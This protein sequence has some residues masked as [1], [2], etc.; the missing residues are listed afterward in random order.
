MPALFVD[1]AVSILIFGSI[2]TTL[3]WSDY[4]LHPETMKYWLNV[5]GEIHFRLPGVFESNPDN[6]VNGSLW[7][8]KPELGCYLIMTLLIA[9]GL[10]KRWPVTLAILVGLW[11]ASWASQQVPF[12]FT[13][14]H[15]L[16]TDVSKLVIFFLAGSLAYLLRYKIPYSP[17][18]A[19][20]SIAFIAA[21]AILAEGQWLMDSRPFMIISIPALTYLTIWLGLQKIPPLPLFKTGDY[22]YG[23][24]LYAYPIQQIVVQATGTREPAI[25]FLLTIVP[26]T[27]VAI[28]SW[29][30]VEKPTLKLRKYLKATPNKPIAGGKEQGTAKPRTAIETSRGGE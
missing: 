29:H 10:V 28:A 12:D 13:G 22:S 6:S 11:L 19:G 30:L 24:Y 5:V 17:W 14:K 18:I 26:V 4:I 25:T 20:A 21:C 3:D 2:L 1:T 8:I 9:S 15:Q 23:I 16:A 7:T 27:L